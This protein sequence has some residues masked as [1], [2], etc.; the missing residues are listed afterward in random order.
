[1][2]GILTLHAALGAAV[3]QRPHVIDHWLNEAS[4]L[5]DRVPDDMKGNWQYF[6]QTNVRIWD[7]AIGV[8]RGESGGTVLDMAG[9]VDQ[10]KITYRDRRACFMADVG[11]G[12]AREPRMRTDAVRWLRRAEDAGPQLI[13]NHPPTRE[14]VGYLLTRTRAEAGGRKLRGMAARMGTRSSPP[15]PV[16]CAPRWR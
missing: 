1:M 11:R 9:N 7:V 5:A 3:V 2:L 12:L 15:T 4:E 16:S 13:R 6:S 14:A 10:S 8:E